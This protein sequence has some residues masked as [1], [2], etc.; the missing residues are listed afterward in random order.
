M[1]HRRKEKH[2]RKLRRRS[3]GKAEVVG[4]ALLSDDPHKVE[5][6]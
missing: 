1:S 5:I 2:G 6:S 4:E 3:C